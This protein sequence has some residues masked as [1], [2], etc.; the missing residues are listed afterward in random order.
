MDF[1]LQNDVRCPL[2][3]SGLGFDSAKPWHGMALCAEVVSVLGIKW[4]LIY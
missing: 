3:S 2:E 1:M 4:L